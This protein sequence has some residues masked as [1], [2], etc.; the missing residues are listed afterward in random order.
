MLR[1]RVLGESREVILKNYSVIFATGNN[2]VFGGDLSAR[3]IRADINP[4]SERPEAR[5]FDFDPVSRALER[6]PQLVSAALTA[7]RAYLLANSPWIV[8]RQPWG[9]FEKWDRLISGTL[10]WLGYADP[11][12]ARE[13]IINDDPVRMSNVDIFRRLVCSI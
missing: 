5:A 10:T 3:A 12:T 7:L 8:K 6:H 13:R 4:K 11:F 9:G 1:D 2:L